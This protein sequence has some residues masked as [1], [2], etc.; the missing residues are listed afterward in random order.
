[1]LLGAAAVVTAATRPTALPRYLLSRFEAETVPSDGMVMLHTDLWMLGVPG[2]GADSS[3]AKV[4]RNEALNWTASIGI[5]INH[6]P[7]AINH[8][9]GYYNSWGQQALQLQTPGAAQSP[10]TDG[11]GVNWV[12]HTELWP[13]LDTY[14]GT[15][16]K[17]AVGKHNIS[18]QT[19]KV[20]R[21]G[22]DKTGEFNYPYS[23]ISGG[24]V[25]N[26]TWW[27]FDRGGLP[28]SDYP[29]SLG[30]WRP[31]QPNTPGGGNESAIFVEYYYAK[32]A[33]FQNYTVRISL[34]HFPQAFPAVLMPGSSKNV[35]PADVAA[36][37]STLGRGEMRSLGHCTH[38]DC[39]DPISSGWARYL[40]IPTL[41]QTSRRKALAWHTGCEQEFAFSVAVFEE[42]ARAGL[43]VGGCENT[44]GGIF[45][46]HLNGS[47][48][49][50]AVFTRLF[51]WSMTHDA[52]VTFLIS[53]QLPD[54][55][56]FYSNL[57]QFLQV[58]P[59]P[60]FSLLISTRSSAGPFED[61]R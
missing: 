28:F 21:I 5:G 10:L 57:P 3:F 25:T 8:A 39:P 43:R 33:A 19:I 15:V 13:Q 23:S 38:G 30:G 46:N 9:A 32:L 55:P 12:F 7:P 49:Q 35:Y 29:A 18:A 1:M 27:A 2:P 51:N 37:I 47:A 50:N 61:N 31:G 26:N 41:A 17:L 4:K 59:A 53:G 48:Y 42:A 52:A 44:G 11:T 56:A 16:A 58:P 60:F 14:F 40:L 36:A 45:N 34:K 54:Q 22:M 20:I 6:P 24:G